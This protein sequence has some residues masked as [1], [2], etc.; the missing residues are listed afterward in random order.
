[1]TAVIEARPVDSLNAVPATASAVHRLVV[2]CSP[3]TLQRRFFLPTTFG[4]EMVWARYRDYLLAGP[5]DGTAV[6]AVAGE[7]PVGLLNVI[8]IGARRAEV[9]LVV[10]DA[11]QRRGVAS[12][13]LATELAH[14][15][16]AGWAVLATVQPD[17]WPVRS[18]LRRL[19]PWQLV[20]RDPAA[21]DYAITLPAPLL[22][23]S[24][25]SS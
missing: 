24:S 3:A 10:A 14:P 7:T 17:N 1:M 21:W 4:Q 15:R 6:L 13:L 22:S 5:P 8:V 23:V 18:L 19:G 2:A 11:W 25:V 20:D 9:S 12:W 16:W